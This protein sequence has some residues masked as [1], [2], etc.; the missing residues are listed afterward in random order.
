MWVSHWN[1][2]RKCVCFRDNLENWHNFSFNTLASC[3]LMWHFIGP[4][5]VISLFLNVDITFFNVT[6]NP[7]NSA[8]G[9]ARSYFCT[10]SSPFRAAVALKSPRSQTIRWLSP[11]SS[12]PHA[13]SAFGMLRSVMSLLV[14]L[15]LL[16][17]GL[18]DLIKFFRNS[19]TVLL[20]KS[21]YNNCIK[22]FELTFQTWKLRQRAHLWYIVCSGSGRGIVEPQRSACRWVR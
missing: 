8:F 6:K 21:M 13:Y 11:L 9:H 18:F 1:A 5:R 16:L 12:V 19:G 4:R 2:C 15:F 14:Q 10:T 7:R 20:Q 3:S 17:P 22:L